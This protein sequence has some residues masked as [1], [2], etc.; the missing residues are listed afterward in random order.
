MLRV[1]ERGAVVPKKTIYVREADLPLWE[2][3]E[4]LS[5]DDSVSAVLSE[6]LSQ[7]LEGQRALEGTVW[8]AGAADL[9]STR[10]Q[11]VSGGWMV[12]VP[13]G[14]TGEPVIQA[15]VAA[16][17]WT[18]DR[19][20]PRSPAGG[21]L[22]VWVPADAITSIWITTARNAGGT[23]YLASARDAW[24]ILLGKARAGETMTYS[25]LG[26]ELGGLHPLRQ[27]PQVLDVIERWCLDHNLPDLTGVVVSQSSGLPG[28]GYF[29]ENGWGD[30]SVAD[31]VDC[32]RKAQARLRSQAWPTD[33]PF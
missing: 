22:W 18:A 28:R 25:A 21:Q 1:A 23:D 12:A 24:A 13:S 26:S 6:A 7:Y 19:P 10:I 27:V 17:R 8:L 4:A 3:A 5:Q 30:L 33:P 29:R 14:A 32:W 2:R 20:I 15:L 11:P 16:G 9:I 31:Q